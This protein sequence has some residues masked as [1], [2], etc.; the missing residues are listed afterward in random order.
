[1]G[2]FKPDFYRSLLLGFTVGAVLVIGAM[3]LNIGS[4]IITS[5]APSAEAAAPAE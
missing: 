1:M 5:V 3:G 2:L 4:G